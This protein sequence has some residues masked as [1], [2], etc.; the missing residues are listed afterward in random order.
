MSLWYETTPKQVVLHLTPLSIA[1]KFNG[2]VTQ[3]RR[4]WVFTSATLMVDNGFSHFTEHMGLT[5]AQTLALESPFD[6]AAQ[7]MLCVP[8]YLPEPSNFAMKETLIR[9]SIELIAAAQG[10][11]FLLF[12][13]HAMLREVANALETHIDNE[14]LV[15]GTTTK[16]ALLD[17]YIE[18]KSAVLLA[19]GAFWEGVDV[20][21]DDLLCVLIDKLPFA[22]PDDP[23]LQAKVEDA[24]KRGKNPFMHVQIPQAVITLKQGAGRLIRDETDKGVLVICDSRLVTKDYGKIFLSSLPPMRRTRQL[25]KA[26]AFLTSLVEPEDT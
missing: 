21:G 19:T 18:N 11:C 5:Q 4:T 25:S 8:H 20:R 1:E 14:L 16:Q 2:I 13:S 7:A 9:V 17:R 24:Q 3:P 15:Q 26:T 12:T 22:S 23:L 6:Y 10:R